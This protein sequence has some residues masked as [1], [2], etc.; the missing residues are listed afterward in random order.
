MA[1]SG[2][3][4]DWRTSVKGTNLETGLGTSSAGKLARHQRA[5]PMAHLTF[6]IDCTRGKQLS[7]T[8]SPVPARVS[9]PHRGPVTLPL[10]TYIVFCGENWPSSTQKIPVGSKGLAQARAMLPSC[11]GINAPAPSWVSLLCPQEVREAKERPLKPVPVRSS[12]WGTVKNSLR[13]LSSCV[14]GQAE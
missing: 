4:R 5:V 3:P 8:A 1:P 11:R 13:V 6:V 2:H 9:S 14:C 7:L 12:T 10:K